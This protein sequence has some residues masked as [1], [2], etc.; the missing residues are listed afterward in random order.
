MKK[1]TLITVLS[2]FCLTP[3]F[4]Q[5]KN[6]EVIEEGQIPYLLGKINK[7]GLT[8]EHYNNWFS[9]NYNSY[10]PNEVVI[11]VLKN[12]LSDYTIKLFL[13]TWCGDSKREV[14]GFLKILD[15]ASFPEN[16]LEMIAL[17]SKQGMYKKSPENYEV[18]LNIHRVPTFIIYKDGKEVGRIIE[19]PVETLEK[20]LLNI[21]TGKE[22][23][24]NYSGVEKI[25]ALLQ[26]EDLA[27]LSAQRTLIA[28]SLK[29][30]LKKL[31]EL[32]NYARILYG[33]KKLTE[34]IEVLKLNAVLFPDEFSNF[35]WIGNYYLELNNNEKALKY[36]KKALELNS[37]NKEFQ[38]TVLEL[39]SKLHN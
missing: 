33:D 22:Y 3:I 21:C 38:K 27:E 8:T 17:S 4:S 31:S 19:F 26:T 11:S 2:L 37:E 32:N 7:N 5:T 29:H 34:A 9:T 23:V 24:P 6:K 39:E 18:G 13:G 35:Y 10:Q 12:I 16:Q 15:V 20:D 14:P 28:E 36:Y 25:H 30:H 1:I